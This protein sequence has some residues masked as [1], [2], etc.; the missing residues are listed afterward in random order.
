M[1]T[2]HN[3]PRDADEPTR[4]PSGSGGDLAR[5]EA[6]NSAATAALARLEQLTGEARTHVENSRAE[7]TRR[8]Y[9]SDWA[10]FLDWCQH[11]GRTPLPSSPETLA[12]YLTD[13]AKGSRPARFSAG[14]HP[15]P[16]PMPRPVMPSHR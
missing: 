15:L 5:I 1:G 9:R 13:C 8:A 3:H 7:N 6:D 4:E 2:T 12:L 10:D 14:W 11:H 16:R